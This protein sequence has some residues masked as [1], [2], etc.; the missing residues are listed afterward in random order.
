M[1]NN[2]TV[3]GTLGLLSIRILN[4]SKIYTMWV[5]MHNNMTVKVTP[6]SSSQRTSRYKYLLSVIKQHLSASKRTL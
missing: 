3:H 2:M 1:H 6:T 4:N 5:L